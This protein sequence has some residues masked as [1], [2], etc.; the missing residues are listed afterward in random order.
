MPRGMKWTKAETIA[1]VEAFV[2]IS[3]DAA[4]GVNRGVRTRNIG[5][6]TPVVSDEGG[7]HSSKQ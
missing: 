5:K 7:I 2:H 4:V 3:E 6:G 1:V